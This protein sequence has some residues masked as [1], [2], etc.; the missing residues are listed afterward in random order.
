MGYIKRVRDTAS[1]FFKLH[2]ER[3]DN[4]T[5]INVIKDWAVNDT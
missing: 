1:Q 2:D 4:G 5:G 3:I